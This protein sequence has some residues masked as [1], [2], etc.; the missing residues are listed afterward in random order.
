MAGCATSR[1]IVVDRRFD[2]YGQAVELKDP[3]DVTEAAERLQVQVNT[4]WVWRKRHKKNPTMAVPEPAMRFGK[5]LVWEWADLLEWAGRTG[6]L[7][8]EKLRQEYRDR[9]GREPREERTAGPLSEDEVAAL[10]APLPPR[11]A[12]RARTPKLKGAPQPPSDGL[13]TVK[14]GRRPESRKVRA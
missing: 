9:F 10:S 1:R 14:P 2:W 13:Q 6:R 4:I 5:V 12:A 3:V 8:D 11:P 7:R